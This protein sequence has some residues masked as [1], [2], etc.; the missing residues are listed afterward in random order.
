MPLLVGDRI[1]SVERESLLLMLESLLVQHLVSLATGSTRPMISKN[2]TKLQPTFGNLLRRN[3]PTFVTKEP[4]PPSS[5][6]DLNGFHWVMDGSKQLQLV[7]G[8]VTAVGCTAS[9]RAPLGNSLS[10]FMNH[11]PVLV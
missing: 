5:S 3:H 11:D 9:S 2:L 1:L 6:R 4:P 7:L 10:A 8:N